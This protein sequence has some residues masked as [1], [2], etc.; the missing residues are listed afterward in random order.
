MTRNW[1][2]GGTEVSSGRKALAAIFLLRP[3]WRHHHNNFRLPHLDYLMI[4]LHLWRCV[5]PQSWRNTAFSITH[6]SANLEKCGSW[7]YPSIFGSLDVLGL[8]KHC[9]Q[10]PRRHDGASKISERA[11]ARTWFHARQIHKVAVAHMITIS[12]SFRSY[13]LPPYKTERFH[14]RR[15]VYLTIFTYNIAKDDCLVVGCPT[16]RTRCGKITL[17]T[18]ARRESCSHRRYV[19]RKK[20]K[21]WVLWE[22]IAESASETEILLASNFDASLV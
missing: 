13:P 10:L 3:M 19:R 17:T 12:H 2:T 18:Q 11:A 21:V 22:S 4:Q 9:T 5:S 6:F 20:G 1:R 7:V 14:L 16:E 15:N 8:G